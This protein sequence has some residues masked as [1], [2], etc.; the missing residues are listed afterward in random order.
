VRF[1][2]LSVNRAIRV[3]KEEFHFN[4][5]EKRNGNIILFRKDAEG[6]LLA[7][8]ALPTAHRNLGEA[9]LKLALRGAGISQEDF[10][11]ALSR[12]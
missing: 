3:F 8:V 11:K 4:Q 1:A 2:N 7:T 10:Q 5:E 9:T 6:T 12:H